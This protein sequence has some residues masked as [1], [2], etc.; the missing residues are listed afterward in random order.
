MIGLSEKAIKVLKEVRGLH[1]SSPQYRKTRN[2]VELS[3]GPLELSSSSSW[4]CIESIVLGK[5][6]QLNFL[7]DLCLDRRQYL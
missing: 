2:D 3:C 1:Q 6:R 7:R 5:R 4:K